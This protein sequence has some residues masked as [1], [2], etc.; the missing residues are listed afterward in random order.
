MKGGVVAL[1]A[2]VHSVAARDSFKVYTSA[3]GWGAAMTVCANDGGAL[4]PIQSRKEN[5]ELADLAR[6]NGATTFW[7]AGVRAAQCSSD[8]CFAWA[9]DATGYNSGLAGLGDFNLP[10][11]DN[12]GN[13]DF[14]NRKE[15]N[16]FL[17]R[18]DCIT[19]VASDGKW[20][21]ADC[22]GKRAFI[23]KFPGK[24]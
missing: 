12:D 22:A 10:D 15:P 11:S 17:N 6:Q 9:K 19:V 2:L 8:S 24:P 1:I 14:W 16:N 13:N 5:E 21:D 4:A 7:T 23:C 20:N 18:E 3:K